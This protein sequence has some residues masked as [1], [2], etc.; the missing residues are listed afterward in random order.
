VISQRFE[1]AATRWAPRIAIRG[2]DHDISYGSVNGDANR[3]ARALTEL[4]DTDRE[5]PVG[6]LCTDYAHTTA[7]LFGIWK[8]SRIV[9]LLDPHQPLE[10]LQ[11]I[12]EHA[13]CRQLVCDA[14]AREVARALRPRALI[15]CEALPRT[16]CDNPPRRI[17]AKRPLAIVYTSGS[18]GVPKGVV[19]DH[20]SLMSASGHWIEHFNFAP[21]DRALFVGNP[22]SISGLCDMI[23]YSVSGLSLIHI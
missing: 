6:V 11:T 19:H 10:R 13:G 9:L 1:Q 18:T 22:S 7:G 21:S 3:I 15:E 17:D 23:K 20:D 2:A 12:A 16:E 14:G 5:L 4:G 8:A